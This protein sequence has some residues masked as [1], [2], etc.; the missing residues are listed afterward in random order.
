MAARRFYQDE[1]GGTAIEFAIVAPILIFL[2]FATLEVAVVGMMSAGLDNAIA[3]TGRM[4]RTGQ[5]DGPNDAP[6][7]EAFVCQALGE[8]NDECRARL[9][10][11]VQR[12]AN[13]GQAA[14]AA[15]GLPDGTFNK[16]S[17]GDIIMVRASY[18]YPLLTP[19][20]GFYGTPSA[21][22][23]VLLDARTAFKNEPY[24]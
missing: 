19:Q 3:R 1:R 14:A 13:F 8:D 6:Q 15:S 16:G 23:E 9:Q 4:I 22:G 24:K 21:A 2:L 20:L 11:S 12:Y 17:A 5:S 10:V 7:F 18:R